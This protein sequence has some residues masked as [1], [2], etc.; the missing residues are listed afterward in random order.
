[1]GVMS[2]FPDEDSAKEWFTELRWPNGPFCPVCG[3]FDVQSGVR[4][5]TMTHRCRDC[6]EK[7]FFSLKLGTVME[8]SK[9]SYQKWAIAIYLCMVNIKGV[10]SM[11]LHR[12]LG[13]TQKSAW[14][15]MHRLRKMFECDTRAFTGSVEVDETY[16]GGKRRNMSNAKRRKLASQGRGAVGK[17]AVVGM[18]DRKTKQVKAKPVKA[19]DK[20]TLQGFVTENVSPKATVY[21]DEAAAYKG[22]PF[23]HKSVNHSTG[24]YVDGMAHTNGIESFWAMLKRG[25]MGTY[26]KMSPKHLERYVNEFAGRHNIRDRDTIDQMVIAVQGMERK[27]LRYRELI[28]DNGLDSG[29]RSGS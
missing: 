3:S 9:L 22:L 12:E 25:Y 2:L 8:G 16:I 19:T 6:P 21:T 20:R 10:S 4:H 7:T 5:R 18:K 13:I 26:H 27:R 1:M 11:K 24:Q 14:F 23:K 28:A 15:M 17:T 29:A